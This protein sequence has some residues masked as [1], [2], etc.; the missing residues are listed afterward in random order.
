MSRALSSVS[1]DQRPTISRL[2]GA[3]DEDGIDIFDVGISL[4]ELLY[5]KL[6]YLENGFEISPSQSFVAALQQILE[7]T[8]VASKFG[9]RVW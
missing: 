5:L 8:A 6:G 3:G 4:R 1:S 2:T 7:D 9:F